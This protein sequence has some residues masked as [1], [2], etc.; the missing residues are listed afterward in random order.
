MDDSDTIKKMVRLHEKT[1]SSIVAVERVDRDKTDKYGVIATEK[2]EHDLPRIKEIVE[3]PKPEVAPSN[4]AVVGRYIFTPALFDHLEKTEAGVGG[5]IQLTDAIAGLLREES[6]YAYELQ[7]RRF[8][9]GT[10]LGYLEAN[11][12][13]ALYNEEVAAGFRAYLDSFNQN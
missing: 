11:V 9:C 2:G 4:L 13:F 7:G 3:K 12:H 10:K 5:E 6:V 1:G 8:D